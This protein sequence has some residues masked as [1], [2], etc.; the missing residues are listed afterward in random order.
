M[1]VPPIGELKYG[2]G[3]H[4]FFFDVGVAHVS[5]LH[6]ML[7]GKCPLQPKV[8]QRLRPSRGGG[9]GFV[10]FDTKIKDKMAFGKVPGEHFWTLRLAFAVEL[11][12]MPPRSMLQ[13]IEVDIF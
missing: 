7:L 9:A 8:L 3:L 6:Q 11:R 1:N 13:G 10:L 5:Q 4:C 12:F 2:S